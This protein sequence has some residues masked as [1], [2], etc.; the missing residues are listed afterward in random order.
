MVVIGVS[1][2][3]TQVFA[4][5]QKLALA[6]S[7]PAVIQLLDDLGAQHDSLV[8]EWCEALLQNLK[9]ESMVR[10]LHT[11]WN[12]M[13]MSYFTGTRRCWWVKILHWYTRIAWFRREYYHCQHST[14]KLRCINPRI[15]QADSFNSST[16]V[17]YPGDLSWRKCPFSPTTKLFS[18]SEWITQHQYLPRRATHITPTH[19]KPAA[20][21]HTES[22]PTGQN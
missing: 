4:R 10:V 2:F 13:R 3:Y 16:S 17:R 19:T 11:K 8:K 9:E 14:L 21:T 15:W 18:N 22:T 1:Y 7:Y 20:R 6:V 5:L 12:I